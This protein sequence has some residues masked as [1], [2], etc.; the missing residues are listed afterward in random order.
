MLNGVLLVSYDNPTATGRGQIC[1]INPDGTDFRELTKK[2]DPLSFVSAVWSPGM[3]L[4]AV[5]WAQ[6]STGAG[7]LGKGLGANDAKATY[8]GLADADGRFLS[9]LQRFTTAPA[10]P[11]WS[12]DGSQIVVTSQ[13]ANSL[14]QCFVFNVPGGR[15][16]QMTHF[17]LAS[18]TIT[19]PIVYG[20]ERSDELLT[21]VRKFSSGKVWFELWTMDLSGELKRRIFEEEGNYLLMPD[22]YGEMTVC[23]YSRPGGMTGLLAFYDGDST[24][25]SLREELLN[26][27]YG[28]SY[29]NTKL[30]PDGKS[31][32]FTVQTSN[33]TQ[34]YVKV[35][36]TRS[37]RMIYAA[38][39]VSVCDWK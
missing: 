29:G 13:D 26:A 27:E 8:L 38:P 17:S 32:C 7:I 31:L 35:L 18:G 2:S 37:E 24:T 33:E 19:S 14:P 4:L 23:S 39:A 6:G 11:V 30:S 16:R 3:D 9:T 10:P 36:A 5:V 15:S 28:Q 12:P 34:V 25:Q 21:C 20:W 1:I 22:S